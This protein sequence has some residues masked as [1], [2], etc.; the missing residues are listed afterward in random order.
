MWKVLKFPQNAHVGMFTIVAPPPTKIQD[1]QRRG[2]DRRTLV[3][4]SYTFPAETDNRA[5]RFSD[6]TRCFSFDTKRR[7]PSTPLWPRNWSA[8]SYPMWAMDHI[9][10]TPDIAEVSWGEKQTD[11]DQ[12][13]ANRSGILSGWKIIEELQK[14]LQKY[15]QLVNIF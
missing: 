4:A 3:K 7:N 11:V 15:S 13:C 10:V 5:T 8:P 1:L 6:G 12:H 2:I 9:Q 14:T